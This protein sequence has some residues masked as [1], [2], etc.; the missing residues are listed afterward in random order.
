MEDWGPD[1]VS[2]KSHN[3]ELLD[4]SQSKLGDFEIIPSNSRQVRNPM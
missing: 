3:F 1:R 2:H 4:G